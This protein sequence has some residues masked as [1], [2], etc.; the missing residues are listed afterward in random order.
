MGRRTVTQDGVYSLNLLSAAGSNALHLRGDL[1]G[2]IAK[3]GYFDTDNT[4]YPIKN[5]GE[6]D[7]QDITE[8]PIQAV[9]DPGAGKPVY[10][11]IEGASAATKVT[12][13]YNG[14]N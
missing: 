1:G 4:F 14:V 12:I 2:A 6:E 10:V 8:L 9:L 3:L 5:M 13:D 7:L 11:V